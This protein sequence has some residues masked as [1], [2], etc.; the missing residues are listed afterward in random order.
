MLSLT[1]QE[2]AVAAARLVAWTFLS[3]LALQ[4][5]R[6][7]TDTCGSPQVVQG[8]EDGLTEGSEL[9]EGGEGEEALVDPM[10][11][12]DISLPYPRVRCDITCLLYTSPSPRD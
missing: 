2:G 7:V 10:Q 5:Q 6:K 3:A 1:R 9:S 12:K 4:L 8:R 11:V